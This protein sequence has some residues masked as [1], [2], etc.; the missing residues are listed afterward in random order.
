MPDI[1]IVETTYFKGNK[2]KKV[3]PEKEPEYGKLSGVGTSQYDVKV[4]T[5]DEVK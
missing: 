1:E 4:A 3:R 2:A 5:R